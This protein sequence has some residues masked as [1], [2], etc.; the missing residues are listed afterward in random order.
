LKGDQRNATGLFCLRKEIAR[1]QQREPLKQE[2]QEEMDA[3]P[4]EGSHSREGQT[5]ARI[6]LHKMP[7]GRESDKGPLACFSGKNEYTQAG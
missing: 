2:D 5:L 7:Q 6:R 3:K 4:P 1:W